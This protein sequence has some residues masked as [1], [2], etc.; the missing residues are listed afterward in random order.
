MMDRHSQHYAQTSLRDRASY[1]K[2]YVVSM[3]PAWSIQPGTWQAPSFNLDFQGFG[4][5][6][7]ILGCPLAHALGKV[8]PWNWTQVSKPNPIPSWFSEEIA[9]FIAPNDAPLVVGRYL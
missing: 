4:N 9:D 1:V 2:S 5:D 6:R 8:L 7:A 3:P